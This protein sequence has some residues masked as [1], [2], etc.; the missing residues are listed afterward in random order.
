MFIGEVIIDWQLIGRD[1][2][3]TREMIDDDIFDTLFISNFKIK[4]LKEEDSTNE[5]GL[6]SFLSIRYRSAEWSVNMVVLV[7]SR[8]G[9]KFS[10]A[11][12]T[13]KNSFSVVV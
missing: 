1:V 6:L 5:S 9:R 13:V 7:S 11:N 8:Y 12:I 3:N 10:N 2:R 4:L